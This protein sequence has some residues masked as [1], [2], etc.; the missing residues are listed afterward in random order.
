[1]PF[2][3]AGVLHTTSDGWTGQAQ[4]AAD[5]LAYLAHVIACER[6]ITSACDVPVLL[7]VAVTQVAHTPCCVMGECL[8]LCQARIAC[9]VFHVLHCTA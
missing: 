6:Y 7:L 3:R 9:V 8:M 1:M 4:R 5:L 2:A